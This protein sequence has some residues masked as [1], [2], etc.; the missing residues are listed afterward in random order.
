MKAAEFLLKKLSLNNR[1]L[2]SLA[3]LSPSLIQD[4][5]VGTAFDILGYGST[6]FRSIS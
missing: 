4:E 5:S 6:K 3:A 1:T 2:P